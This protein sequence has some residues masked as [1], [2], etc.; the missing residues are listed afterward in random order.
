L[1][2]TVDWL[3]NEVAR[4]WNALARLNPGATVAQASAEVEVFGHA[5]PM[6]NG[7]PPRWGAKR[8]TLFE[9]ESGGYAVF[10]AV[11]TILMVAV[12]LTLLTGCANVVNLLAARN[13]TRERELA[14][15]LALGAG[16]LRLIRQ[17]CT[18]SL[19]LGLLGGA[20][21]WLFSI[22][23]CSA[24][25]LWV[26]NQAQ[27]IFHG[28]LNLFVD[29]A[30][31][32]RVLVYTTGVSLL[33]GLAVGLWPAVRATRT[34]LETALK[35]EAS[36][37]GGAARG[38]WSRRNL[39]LT[40][41]VTLSLVL[42]AGAG[43]LFRGA[44]HALTT[45]PG[46]ETKHLFL[47][48]F[49]VRSVAPTPATQAALL[50]EAVERVQALPE[51]ASAS[52]ATHVPF[53]GHSIS[54]LIT[55][56]DVWM[57]G[58]VLNQVTEDYFTTLGLPLVAGRMFTRAEIEAGAMVAVVSESAARLFWPD[59]NPLGR[60]ISGVITSRLRPGAR[61]EMFVVVGV[62]KDARM[63]LLSKADRANVFYPLRPTDLSG[64]ILV[65]SRVA[66]EAAYHA[67]YAAAGAVNASLRSQTTIFG[68]EQGP[69]QLQ[70]LMA[71]APATI[72]A[73][74]GGLALVLASVGVYGV[75]SFVVARRTREIG[76]HLALGA[77]K[78][79]VVSLILRQTL[80][81]V[82]WGAGFG[83][84]GAVALSMLLERALVNPEIP[85]LTYGA[86]ALPSATLLSVLGTLLAVIFTAALIPARRATKVDPMV[87]LRCE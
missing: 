86:G 80:R 4:H 83:L 24:I 78:R 74:L 11:I 15:R 32:W 45:D 67:V 60:R 57:N 27:E 9:T 21:G 52:R 76:V 20:G 17:L 7:Q 82:A 54:T 56:D 66:P 62:V 16:R 55:D 28:A 61:P 40:L 48:N 19:L 35:Q 50:R 30:P 77:Q 81:P 71:A 87:A 68:F 63:T 84:V 51:I 34:N 33:T 25:R 49:N 13:A 47:L 43:L 2:P 75:V 37:L 69:M 23:A 1:L 42:L 59:R 41:Q 10:T 22:W 79:D 58:C 38:P 72:A 8:A 64:G 29:L 85:D 65:R 36:G 6:E 53:L 70:R 73:A 46:F 14:V 31:D 12:A 5:W 44:S 18:E 39:L 3:H 26:M